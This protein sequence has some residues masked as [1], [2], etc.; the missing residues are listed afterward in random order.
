MKHIYGTEALNYTPHLSPWELRAIGDL[1]GGSRE[2][3]FAWIDAIASQKYRGESKTSW[4]HFPSPFHTEI[5]ALAASLLVL[6]EFYDERMF[7]M[8]E[9]RREQFPDMY[10]D[11][12]E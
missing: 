9:Q 3:S 2:L 8:L 5:S 7:E 11:F 6:D 10:P 12:E 1:S 4:P